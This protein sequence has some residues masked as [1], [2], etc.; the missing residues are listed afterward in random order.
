MSIYTKLASI[1][2]WQHEIEARQSAPMPSEERNV[3]ALP[4]RADAQVHVN[5]D[6]AT[7][8]ATAMACATLNARSAAMLPVDV[9]APRGTSEPDGNQKLSSHPVEALLSVAPNVEMTAFRFREALMMCAQFHGNAYAE[10]ERDLSGRPVGLWP[11]HPYRVDPYRNDA[12]LK[13]YEVDNGQGAKV[14]I[15]DADMF[16]LA[17]PSFDGQGGLSV[18]SYARHTLGLAI[19]QEQ[20]ASSF[21]ANQAAPSGMVKIGAGMSAEPLKRFKAEFNRMYTGKRRAG[22]VLFADADV[23]W[24]PFG[25]PLGDAEFLAQRRFSVEQV[26][27]FFGVPP[28][29]IGD[30]SKQTFANFEQ[31]NLAYLT[32]GLLPWLV[33]LE[34]EANRKLIRPTPGR[35]RPFVK[36]NASAIVRADLE[37]RYRAYALG[38][39]WGWFSVNDIRRLEDMEP[40]GPAGDEYL[41]PLNMG[42]GGEQPP[43]PNE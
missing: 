20:F 40:I 1:F 39:Q 42:P 13:V 23:Q 17:G 37:K 41:V 10:I 14:D 25:M 35:P 34:Q 38:R 5:E 43:T 2:R 19:A 12:G 3:L 24:T 22:R 11:I 16:C 33:R 36:I 26:C 8:E 18:I 27:R 6:T 31:A 9:L 30:T 28:Q 21:M 32:D 7:S 4:M 15:P 29:K